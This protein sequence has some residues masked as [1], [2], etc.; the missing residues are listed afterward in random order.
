MCKITHMWSV[1]CSLVEWDSWGQGLLWVTVLLQSLSDL[2][3]FSGMDTC[4]AFQ[5][6]TK[7]LHLGLCQAGCSCSYRDIHSAM[8]L[9]SS[10]FSDPKG[11]TLQSTN[12][13]TTFFSFN[14]HMWQQYLAEDNLPGSFHL[15]ARYILKWSWMWQMAS[16]VPNT[17]RWGSTLKYAHDV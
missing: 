16:Q 1:Q 15:S 10:L 14:V 12:K 4:H 17:Q 7:S 11:H 6:A 13:F 5:E 2:L 8:Y 9:T 3:C